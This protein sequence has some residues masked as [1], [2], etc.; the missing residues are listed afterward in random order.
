M[1]KELQKNEAIGKMLKDPK[2]FFK[3][4]KKNYSKSNCEVGPFIDDDGEVISDRKKNCKYAGKK[5][6]KT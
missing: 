1:I 3:N 6:G 5:Q 4:S 2:T